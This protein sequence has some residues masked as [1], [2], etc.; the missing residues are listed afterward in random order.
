MEGCREAVR[1]GASGLL[2]PVRDAHALAA[3]LKQL[4]SNRAQRA[5]FGRTAREI[6]VADFSLDKVIEQT[7][8]LYRE[9]L[10]A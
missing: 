2:V 5:T 3:A 4:I 8:A 7:L 9:L 1:H 6:A 10:P